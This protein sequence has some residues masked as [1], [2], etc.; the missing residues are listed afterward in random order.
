M[1]GDV[2]RPG[3]CTA[4]DGGR[5][6]RGIVDDVG[7]CAGEE[8]GLLCTREL[9]HGE[10][11]GEQRTDDHGRLSSSWFLAKGEN[12]PVTLRDTRDRHFLFLHP[13]SFRFVAPF[14]NG[15]PSTSQALHCDFHTPDDHR[16]KRKRR[17]KW[18]ESFVHCWYVQT[19]TLL[20]SLTRRPSPV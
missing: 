15:P 6:Q 12:S 11:D 3:A 13:H 9:K 4:R 7:V 5:T 1:W 14:S 16:R 8:D 2:N 17:R 10:Q 19:Q 20:F 18:Q